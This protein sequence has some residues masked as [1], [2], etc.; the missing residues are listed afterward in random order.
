MKNWP[1]LLYIV[2]AVA[3][4]A[5]ILYLYRDKIP[6]YNDHMNR[7]QNNQ[8]PAGKL[9][10]SNKNTYVD[11]AGTVWIRR[12]FLLSILHNPLKYYVFESHDPTCQSSFEVEATKTDFDAG[13]Q[14]FRFATYNFFSSNIHPLSHFFA[15]ILPILLY[16]PIHIF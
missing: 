4:A 16:A 11:E 1:I 10:P 6:S 7:N 8:L 15:D 13:F 2:F 3:V 5:M 14:S 12:T 9:S